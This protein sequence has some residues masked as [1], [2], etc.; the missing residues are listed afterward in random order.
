M[1]SH[2]GLNRLKVTFAVLVTLVALFGVVAGSI[3]V[4]NT[5][6][7]MPGIILSV[8]CI[9]AWFVA[10]KAIWEIRKLSLMAILLTLACMISIIAFLVGDIL[11]TNYYHLNSTLDFGI[12]LYSAELTIATGGAITVIAW[13]AEGFSMK[14]SGGDSK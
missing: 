3:S 10:D 5:A 7:S 4:A 12:T 14:N 8:G 13:I 2:D 6:L 1:I 9:I 11:F